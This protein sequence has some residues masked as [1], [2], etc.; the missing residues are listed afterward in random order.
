MPE[1]KRHHPL[2]MLVSFPCTLRE[3]ATKGIKTRL[4]PDHSLLFKKKKKK[5]E[6]G[7][8]EKKEKGFKKAGEQSVYVIIFFTVVKVY[9]VLFL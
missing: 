8:G 4:P 3:R 9:V 5:R 1:K 7:V 6:G 2:S